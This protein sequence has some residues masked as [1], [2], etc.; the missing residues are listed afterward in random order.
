MIIEAATTSWATV[1][2]FSTVLNLGYDEGFEF[3]EGMLQ[4][5]QATVLQPPVWLH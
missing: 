3:R 1:D 5:E 2:K 4:V